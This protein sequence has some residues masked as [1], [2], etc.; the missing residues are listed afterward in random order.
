VADP[1]NV[2]GIPDD[3][4]DEQSKA[5]YAA[6]KAQTIA[7]MTDDPDWLKEPLFP[8]DDLMQELERL[9]AEYKTRGSTK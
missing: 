7:E 6:F 1:E 9:H 5:Q 2:T 4:W 3:S 8:L